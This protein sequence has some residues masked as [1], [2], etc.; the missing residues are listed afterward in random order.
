[1][2]KLTNYTHVDAILKFL[3]EFTDKKYCCDKR[4]MK[5]FIDNVRCILKFHFQDHAI[6]LQC[7][8]AL[9]NLL[10]VQHLSY[11]SNLLQDGFEDIID[12]LNI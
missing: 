6:Y 9:R 2:V 12:M 4:V 1:M 3:T 7:L 8:K 10:H 11:E 5:L